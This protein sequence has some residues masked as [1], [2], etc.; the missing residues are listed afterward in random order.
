MGLRHD[1][2]LKRHLRR[3]K[4]EGVFKILLASTPK[5]CETIWYTR[6]YTIL[7][8]LQSKYSIYI[9]MLNIIYT[10]HSSKYHVH[11]KNITSQTIINYSTNT[12]QPIQRISNV[13]SNRELL[14]K[15]FQTHAQ[16]PLELNVECVPNRSNVTPNT[17]DD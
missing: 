16:S 12:T 2:V 9:I 11:L 3:W 5:L 4:K 17:L 1:V 8:T 14:V 10:K 15:K 7:I 6:A 13:R